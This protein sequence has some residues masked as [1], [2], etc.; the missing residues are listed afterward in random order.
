MSAFNANL[1]VVLQLTAILHDIS[2]SRSEAVILRLLLSI[3]NKIH[4]NKGI[5]LLLFATESIDCK[6]FSKS[7]LFSTKFIF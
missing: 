3:S 2:V 7:S 4:D 6:G 5:V 1:I